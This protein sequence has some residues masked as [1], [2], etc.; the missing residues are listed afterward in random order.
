[1]QKTRRHEKITIFDLQLILTNPCL[2]QTRKPTV[3][4]RY[5]IYLAPHTFIL[6]SS[7][8]QFS[9]SSFQGTRKMNKLQKSPEITPYIKLSSNIGVHLLEF[10]PPS[11]FNSNCQISG[12]DTIH[13]HNC[14]PSPALPILSL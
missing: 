6:S 9:P 7:I 1:M 3:G 14:F 5:I 4:M 2:A 10:P 8:F 13:P 11:V 12:R